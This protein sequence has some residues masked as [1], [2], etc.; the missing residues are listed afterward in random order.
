MSQPT[1]VDS[2]DRAQLAHERNLAAND[3]IMAVARL[4]GFQW[5]GDDIGDLQ[6]LTQAID[7]LSLQIAEASLLTM[8]P[9][10]D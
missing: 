8:T 9:A 4:F 7:Y 1:V 2:T 6:Q 10:R 3:L 5:T